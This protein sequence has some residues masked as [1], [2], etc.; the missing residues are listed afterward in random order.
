MLLTFT[1][2]SINSCEVLFV[3][4]EQSRKTRMVDNVDP[5]NTCRGMKLKGCMKSNNDPHTNNSII[6]YYDSIL[7]LFMKRDE[8]FYFFSVL[9]QPLQF[10]KP[11]YVM[12]RRQPHCFVG[13]CLVYFRCLCSVPVCKCIFISISGRFNS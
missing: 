5:I 12:V 4:S 9:C 7:S 10:G 1:Y 13:E 11:L 8:I 3:G 6:V 2:N